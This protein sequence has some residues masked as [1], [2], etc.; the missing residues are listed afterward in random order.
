[1]YEMFN[2]IL[3]GKDTEQIQET[4]LVG[5]LKPLSRLACILLAILGGVVALEASV[6][7]IDEVWFQ[8]M[9]RNRVYHCCDFMD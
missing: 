4:L 6:N 5:Q 9:L 2:S 3:P 1:M 7:G 8:V